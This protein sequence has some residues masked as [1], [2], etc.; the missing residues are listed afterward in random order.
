MTILPFAKNQKKKKR[1][2]ITEMKKINKKQTQKK[3]EWTENP[4]YRFHPKTSKKRTKNP[5][6][7]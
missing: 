7:N 3:N 4:A 5:R 6:L 1:K 2:L